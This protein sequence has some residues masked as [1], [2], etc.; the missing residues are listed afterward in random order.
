MR[1]TRNRS[2]ALHKESNERKS[3]EINKYVNRPC[4]TNTYTQI[5]PH[6]SVC[7]CAFS[8]LFAFGLISL[9]HLTNLANNNNISNNNNNKLRAS[10]KV[11]LSATE[12]TKN[13]KNN[14]GRRPYFKWESAAQR[15]RESVK[16]IE[17]ATLRESGRARANQ[18][19]IPFFCLIFLSLCHNRKSHNSW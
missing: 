7:T 16:L 3:K 15:E 2:L 4:N 10:Q 1:N 5:H 13:K 6:T 9:L 19:N 12:N 11:A 18:F 17:R 8:V 14:A